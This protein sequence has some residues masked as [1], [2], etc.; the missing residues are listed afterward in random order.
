MPSRRGNGVELV[1][2]KSARG[3]GSGTRKKVTHCRFG[4]PNVL[5][6]QLWAFDADKPAAHVKSFK[7]SK[8]RSSR[9]KWASMTPSLTTVRPLPATPDV[10]VSASC[11]HS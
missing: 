8:Q 1:K 9:G 4:L 5:V 6:K 11:G 2:K 3:S 7:L 10:M